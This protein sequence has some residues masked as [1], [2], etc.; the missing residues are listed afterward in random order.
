MK[1]CKILYSP[2]KLHFLIN[3]KTEFSKTARNSEK[4]HSYSGKWTNYVYILEL[5]LWKNNPFSIFYMLDI[6][7]V[8]LFLR[9]VFEIPV[10]TQ[11]CSDCTASTTLSEGRRAYAQDSKSYRAANSAQR[12]CMQLVRVVYPSRLTFPLVPDVTTRTWPSTASSRSRYRLLP[13]RS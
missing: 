11:V 1:S 6:F 3:R 8:F 9:E 4:I 2:W 5:T 13:S 12:W 10:E 7:S